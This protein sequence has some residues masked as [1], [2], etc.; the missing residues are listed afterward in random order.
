[1]FLQNANM[2]QTWVLMLQTFAAIL[3]QLKLEYLFDTL[4][5][6]KLGIRSTVP[7]ILLMLTWL[8]WLFLGRLWQNKLYAFGVFFFRWIW[9]G[10]K[11]S[12][13][14]Y[15]K[16]NGNTYGAQKCIRTKLLKSRNNFVRMHRPQLFIYNFLILLER[17]NDWYCYKKA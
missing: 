2:S 13:L 1:M 5:Y 10:E 7:V 11:R 12:I 8:M 9:G 6:T 3:T 4:S 16:Y 14:S 17:T 15:C